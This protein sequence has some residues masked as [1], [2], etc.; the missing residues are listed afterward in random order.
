MQSGVSQFIKLTTTAAASTVAAALVAEMRVPHSTINAPSDIAR[1][2]DATRPSEIP[3]RG[4]KDIM[5]RVYRG[6]GDD[7][8]L[9]G[10]AGVTFY[11]LLSLFPGIAALVSIYA[12]FADP[13]TIAQHL[14]LVTGILPEGGL[15]VI[16]DQLNRIVAEGRLIWGSGSPLA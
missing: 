3:P 16:G 8:I 10:A 12:L 5:T 15:Q 2:R 14:D 1:G 13:Q 9:A 6:I 4:W 11:A 7:R